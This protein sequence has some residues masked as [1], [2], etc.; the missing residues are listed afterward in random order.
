[1]GVP[2]Y[3]ALPA[4]TYDPATPSGD[5]IP[6]EER[7]GDELRFVS[8]PDEAGV[9]RKVAITAA[10]ARN[11]A[12]DVTPAALVTGYITEKGVCAGPEA[13]AAAFGG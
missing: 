8:G 13:L 3:V 2:F 12:F 7:S 4:S 9:M 1:H 6:I 11:P 10:P 5:G